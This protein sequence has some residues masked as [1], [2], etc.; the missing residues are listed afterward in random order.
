MTGRVNNPDPI[1]V[2]EALVADYRETARRNGVD[3][4]SRAI[5]QIALEDL[6]ITD[7]VAREAKPAPARKAPERT[8][9]STRAQRLASQ[10]GYEMLT[11]PRVRAPSPHVAFLGRPPRTDKQAAIIRRVS[12]ILSIR[13]RFRPSRE[14]DYAVPA[15]AS[16]FVELMVDLKEQ[17]REFR[18]LSARDC[19]R[20][21]WA[22]AERICDLSEPRLGKWWVPK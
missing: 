1:W 14:N 13:S 5:E 10:L 17:R 11:R 19:Q 9:P 4:S 15:L 12:Q 16:L 7:A 18:G 3:P 22:R 6:R 2:R 21:F 8:G 20:M